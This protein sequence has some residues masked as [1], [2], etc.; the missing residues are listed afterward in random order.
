MSV[1]R[2][3]RIHII[4]NIIVLLYKKVNIIE[5]V[6]KEGICWMKKMNEK[7]KHGFTLA[8]LL[9]VVAIIIILVAI[10]IPIFTSRLE[11]ARASTCD[12][13]RRSLKAELTTEYISEQGFGSEV[14]DTDDFDITNSSLRTNYGKNF[15]F[16]TFCPEGGVITAK[17]SNSSF[18]VYCT[19]HNNEW[20][21]GDSSAWDKVLSFIDKN[22]SADSGSGYNG[23]HTPAMLNK[24]KDAGFDFEEMGVKSWSFNKNQSDLFYWST[25]DI[26]KM[27]TGD[28][29]PTLCYNSK[30]K[31]YSVM[32]STIQSYTLKPGITYNIMRGYTKY[33]SGG[34]Y[35]YEEAKAIYD[36]I[37]N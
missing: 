11:K 28:K 37:S 3:I 33:G 22:Y 9:V 8:E 2:D 5:P 4:M 31:K 12:A 18:T 29:V 27:N 30:T 19:K 16:D 7:N 15:D 20:S 6:D 24:L 1:L 10:S 23:N 35:T 26:S 25:Q 21:V 32:I 13:N 14:S 36:K 34:E 17:Y